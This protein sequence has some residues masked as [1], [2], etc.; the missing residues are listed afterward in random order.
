MK[1][2]KILLNKY[3]AR[4][5]KKAKKSEY[6]KQWNWKKKDEN[7]KKV[8]RV[9]MVKEREKTWKRSTQTVTTANKQYF[10]K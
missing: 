3:V 8:E 9:G 10:L 6:A 1:R 7:K 2:F 4:N 5:K